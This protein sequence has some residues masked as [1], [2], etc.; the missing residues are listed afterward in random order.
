MPMK[1]FIPVSLVVAVC[2]SAALPGGGNAQTY[3]AYSYFH[4]LT[5]KDTGMKVDRKSTRLNSSHLGISYAVFCL[6]KKKKEL[7][8]CV[9]LFSYIHFLYLKLSRC[10]FLFTYKLSDQIPFCG[11]QLTWSHMMLA[12]FG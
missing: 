11:L 12:T 4:N 2:A 6:K 1:T 7:N 5:L 9:R 10:Y 3:T 8:S